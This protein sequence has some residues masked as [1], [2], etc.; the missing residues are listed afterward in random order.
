MATNIFLYFLY[1]WV[2]CWTVELIFFFI[3]FKRFEKK[4]DENLIPMVDEKLQDI[5]GFKSEEVGM[6]ANKVTLAKKIGFFVAVFL[7]FPNAPVNASKKIFYT[8]KYL[9]SKKSK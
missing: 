3:H 8:I 2:A 9:F 6:D 1:F 7:F 5:T 4:V